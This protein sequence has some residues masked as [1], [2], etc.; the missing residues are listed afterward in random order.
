M[1]TE[2]L[3]EVEALVRGVLNATVIDADLRNVEIANELIEAIEGAG[4]EIS[5]RDP[6][7]ASENFMRALLAGD[8][9]SEALRGF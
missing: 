1:N 3:I 5:R 2:E 7:P 8:D 4:Y 6:G 9:P